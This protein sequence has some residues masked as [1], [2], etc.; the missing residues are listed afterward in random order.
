MKWRRMSS[1]RQRRWYPLAGEATDLL[2]KTFL[3]IRWRYE[4]REQC[5]NTKASPCFK[6]WNRPI[7]SRFLGSCIPHKGSPTNMPGLCSD[8]ESRQGLNFAFSHSIP[9]RQRVLGEKCMMQ[10]PYLVFDYDPSEQ[11]QACSPLDILV[12]FLGHTLV[13]S[14]HT[15]L[16][17]YSLNWQMYLWTLQ[18]PHLSTKRH[19]VCLNAC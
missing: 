15:K 19:G 3:V 2:R 9:K 4:V 11:V 6:R 13:G 16:S 18:L 17:G 12:L 10:A 8:S 5:Q 1:V 14:K 7:N